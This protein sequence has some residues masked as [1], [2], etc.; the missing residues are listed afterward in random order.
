[1]K[2]VSLFFSLPLFFVVN[3]ASATVDCASLKL[4]INAENKSLYQGLVQKVLTEKVS[5]K[6]IDVSEVLAD[7]EWLA[8]FASTKTSEPGVFFFKN[9]KFIDVWG[10]MVEQDEKPNVL[11]WAQGI[12]APGTLTQCFFDEIVIQ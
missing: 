4:K 9:K 10:G 3:I 7:K 2:K 11:K 12:H 5:S 8:I 1:M 6:Q